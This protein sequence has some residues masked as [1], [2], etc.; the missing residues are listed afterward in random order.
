MKYSILILLIYA[1]S[2]SSCVVE[3]P[4]GPQ[5]LQGEVGDAGEK[6][7]PG[8][9]G[10]PGVGITEGVV[11]SEWMTIAFSGENRTWVGIMENPSISQEVLDKGDVL[12]YY[13]TSSGAVRELNF[14]SDQD[15]IT[16]QL[17]L[18]EI[19]ISSTFDASES[20]FRYI[21]LNSGVSEAIGANLNYK[22]ITNVLH[23]K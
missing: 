8:E 18:G 14:F 1:I 15:N 6:G 20:E 21:I 2:F 11:A 22:E 7:E 17:R 5:G 23:I 19:I 4:E 16:Q 3:G 10:E 9:P 12:V 13:K